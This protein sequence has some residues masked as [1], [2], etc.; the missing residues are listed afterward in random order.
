M[1]VLPLELRD[2]SLRADGR[3]LIDAVSLDIE[4]GPKTVILGP[5]GSGKSLLLRLCHG[6]IPPY[7]GTIR[8]RGDEASNSRRRWFPGS[9]L[10][11]QRT[12]RTR[13]RRRDRPSRSV[14]R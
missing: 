12:V 3:A 2:V 1:S 9:I 6:L 10:R 13:T 8:W 14:T 5:N 7:D 11:R 4:A